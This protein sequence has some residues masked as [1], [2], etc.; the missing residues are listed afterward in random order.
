LAVP[1]GEAGLTGRRTAAVDGR[2]D[3]QLTHRQ[4]R[5]G[6]GEVLVDEVSHMEVLGHVEEG[7]NLP[8]GAPAHLEGDVG[9]GEFRLEGLRSSPGGWP[10]PPAASFL[11]GLYQV[12]VG[13]FLELLGADKGFH[14]VQASGQ[15]SGH[16]LI[17]KISEYPG[18]I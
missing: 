1:A 17:M 2:Q 13:T 14:G 11:H 18:L 3:Q 16:Q 7:G 10:L 12:I 15:R 6:P 4:G 8:K 9:L 5:T